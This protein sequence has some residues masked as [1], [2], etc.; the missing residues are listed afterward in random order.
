MQL[1]R[2]DGSPVQQTNFQKSIIVQSMPLKP[3]SKILN[4]YCSIAVEVECCDCLS[5]IKMASD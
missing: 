5:L 4:R 2:E 1:A 3:V